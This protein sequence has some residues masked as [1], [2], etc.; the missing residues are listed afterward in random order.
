[1]TSKEELL[2][3]ERELLHNIQTE[4]EAETKHLNEANNLLTRER[5]VAKDL[6]DILNKNKTRLKELGSALEKEKTHN[7]VIQ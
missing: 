3:K 4:R 2:Q 7:T 6:E 1:M 5:T